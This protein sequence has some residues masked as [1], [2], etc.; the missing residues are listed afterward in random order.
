MSV[1][2]KSDGRWCV[3]YYADN[4]QRWKYFGRGAE[5]EKAAREY[6]SSLKGSGQVREY[7]KRSKSFGPTLTELAEAYLKSKAATLPEVS[8]KNTRYK[9][10]AVI[11]PLIGHYK[12][13]K[14]TAEILDKYVLNRSKAVKM[15]TIHREL[16]DVQA[17]MNWA[18]KR[19]LITHNPVHGFQKPKR[20]DEIIKPPSQQE[21]KAIFDHAPAHLKRALTISYYT[22][23]RPGN[24]ELFKLTCV[25]W[26][27]TM[28]QSTL[29]APKRTA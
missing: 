9:L 4:K 23:L 11:L 7:K 12:A 10:E 6:D 25:T 21:M 22:G 27:L 13:M 24:A 17:I 28:K 16:S 26:I 20:D 1:T 3:V 19:R 8:I 18:V 14:L 2:Q 29:S 5:A 15:T